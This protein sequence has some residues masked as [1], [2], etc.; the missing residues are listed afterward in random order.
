[1]MI[2]R[3]MALDNL[4]KVCQET[5][6]IIGDM[7]EADSVAYSRGYENGMAAEAQVQKT[8][9]PWVG[10]TDEE[11]DEIW[12]DQKR[13]GESITRA[14]EAKLKEKNNANPQAPT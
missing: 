14:I 12:A 5:L 11:R 2:K 13:T 4:I 10:L 9:K 3:D 8:L 1:M 7:V 6:Q